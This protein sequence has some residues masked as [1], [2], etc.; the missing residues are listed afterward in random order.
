MMLY[1]F[2]NDPPCN[3]AHYWKKGEGAEVCGNSPLYPCFESMS[4]LVKVH[5][6]G[7][8]LSLSMG[9]MMLIRYATDVLVKRFNILTQPGAYVTLLLHSQNLTFL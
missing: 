5:F 8:Y 3:F 2:I 1:S 7:K 6:F 9:F 4:T